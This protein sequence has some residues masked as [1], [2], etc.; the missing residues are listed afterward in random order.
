MKKSE[1]RELIREELIRLRES[2]IVSMPGGNNSSRWV[3]PGQSRKVRIEQLSGYTQLDYPIA[4]ELDIS[5]EPYHWAGVS[6]TKKYHNK[7][8]ASRK[9]DGTLTLENLIEQKWLNVE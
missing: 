1:L 6:Q 8:R 5:N 2:S 4:D 3:A 7:V 9:S